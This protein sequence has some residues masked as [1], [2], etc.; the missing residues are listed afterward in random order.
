VGQLTVGNRL[1]VHTK[2]VPRW[3]AAQ[4]E[5]IIAA[6]GRAAEFER[7]FERSSVPMVLVDDERR[8][9]NANAAAQ[10]ALTLTLAKLRQLRLDDLTPPQLMPTMRSAWTQLIETGSVGWPPPYNDTEQGYLGVTSYALANALP[11]QH[12]IA[13]APAG[14]PDGAMLE[15]RPSESGSPLTPRELEVL[16]L[17]AEGNS[18]ASIARKLLVSQATVRTHLE[19]IYA[20]LE[21]HDRAAAVARAMRLGLIA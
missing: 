2:S 14:W 15:E 5:Q 11:G 1:S 17:A 21:V 13:F 6:R 19:H 4:V 9:L 20:K 10:S 7:V 8:Y 12:L 3:V 18:R 16:E